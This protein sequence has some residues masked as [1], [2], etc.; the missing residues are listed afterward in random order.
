MEIPLKLSQS[1]RLRIVQSACEVGLGLEFG[2]LQK[3]E[4]N[5]DQATIR[6]FVEFS[7]ACREVA[8]FSH[9]GLI[10]ASETTRCYL[11][12][13]NL[14]WVCL[15]KNTHFVQSGTHPVEIADERGRRSIS[16][17]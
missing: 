12:R 3:K 17:N 6:G 16:P 13:A 7:D 2:K 9:R 1:L 15:H 4:T 10:L 14:R 8:R 5:V 11:R